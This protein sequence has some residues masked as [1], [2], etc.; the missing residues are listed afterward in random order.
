MKEYQI[1]MMYVRPEDV[2]D[3]CGS[4][5]HCLS[6]R[7]DGVVHH[8]CRLDGHSINYAAFFEYKCNKWKRGN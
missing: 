8:S 7:K 6:R 3:A 2:E 4:C 5:M 1:R